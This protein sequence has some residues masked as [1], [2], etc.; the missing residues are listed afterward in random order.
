MVTPTELRNNIPTLQEVTYLNYGAHGPSPQNIVEAA[1]SF[2]QRHE[3]D[4]PATGDPYETAFGAF[5]ETRQQVA[6]FIGA[7][8]DEIALTESTSAGINAIACAIDWQPGDIVVRTDLEHP[9]G[10]LPWKRL[11]REGVDVRI[12]ETDGGRLDHETYVEAVADARLVTFSAVTWTHGTKL[13]VSELVDIAQDAGAL[14]LVDAVQVPGQ[15][16]MNVGEWGADIVA[17]AGH[18]WLLGLWGSG[19]LYVDHT[20]AE[21]L[22]PRAVGYRSVETPSAVEPTFAPGARRFEIGSANPAP[23]VAL[24]EA[25]QTATEVGL[26][27]IERRIQNLA[28]RLASNV[29][30]N[31][32]LSPASP[33]SGLVTIDVD[34]PNE[35]VSRLA[36]QG[37]VVRALPSPSCIRVSVHAVNTA[38]EIEHVLEALADEW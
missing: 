30:D 6:S 28:G 9:A 2:I 13:P 20:V 37:I 11:E 17:A 5:E 3:Y 31:R 14:T 27:T 36:D 19:F 16:P 7:Q 8:P 35:T 23:H 10:I 32:L 33:E 18:K 12:V 34:A 15:M 25:I 21:Q 4:V 38:D 29:P 1:T 22:E 24:R 26:D